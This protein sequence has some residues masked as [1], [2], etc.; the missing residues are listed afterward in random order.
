MD[1]LI[2]NELRIVSDESGAPLVQDENEY[3]ADIENA[4]GSNVQQVVD[5]DY[6]GLT[7]DPEDIE[8]EILDQ[9]GI[10]E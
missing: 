2:D 6:D 3:N 8:D 9:T 7:Q 4:Q 5:K 10:Q 1:E